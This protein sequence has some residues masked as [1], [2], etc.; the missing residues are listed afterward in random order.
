MYINHRRMDTEVV[1]EEVLA[2]ICFDQGT[3]IEVARE[4]E[5]IC[6]G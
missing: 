6:E 2:H 3:D 1:R 4:D 5:L